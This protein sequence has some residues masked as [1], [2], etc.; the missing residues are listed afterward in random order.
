[1]NQKVTSRDTPPATMYL[2]EVDTLA[3]GV[4][5][6]ED[7]HLGVGT[8]TQRVVGHKRRAAQLL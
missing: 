2:F 3:A 8:T 7:L 4:G 1:M 5:P 6:G